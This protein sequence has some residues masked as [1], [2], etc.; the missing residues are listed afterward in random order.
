MFD[1]DVK[2]IPEEFQD[3]VIQRWQ[4]ILEKSGHLKTPAS[5]DLP[6]QFALVLMGS[7]YF[8]DQCERHPTLLKTLVEENYLFDEFNN[9]QLQL[10]VAAAVD[11]IDSVDDLMRSIREL[12]RLQMCR[13]IFRDI[14]RVSKMAETTQELSIFADFCIDAALGWLYQR[15]C[16]DMGRP[17]N[18]EGE[19]QHLVVIGMGKLGAYE[20]NLSSDVDLIFAYP[21]RGK[22]VG[23]LEID[24]QEFFTKLSQSLIKVLHSITVDGFVFRVDM[25]LRP[26]GNSGSLV[27]SFM[28]IEEYYT[29]HGRG[30]ERYAMIKA[31][32]I[33]GDKEQGQKLLEMLR[34]F[35][36]RRYVDY[37]VLESLRDMKSMIQHEVARN[38]FQDHVKLGEG[39]IREIEFLAQAFQLVHGG[40][41]VGLQ[42]PSVQI[43]LLH[44]ADHGYLPETAVSELDA[45][46]VFLR[47][48]EHGLQSYRDRQ[49]HELPGNLKDQR[50]LARIMGFDT[51]SEFKASL[52]QHREEV[53]KHFQNLLEKPYQA[54]EVQ[55]ELADWR[56]L[57]QDDVDDNFAISFLTQHGYLDV[58]EPWRHLCILK[59]SKKLLFLQ[60]DGR[61][62]IDRF[63]PMVLLRIS[64]KENASMLLMRVLPF[65]EAVVRRSAYFVLLLENQDLLDQ[66]LNLCAASPW[67]ADQIANQPVLIEELHT[68][69]EG[70]QVPDSNRLTEELVRQLAVTDDQENRL[71]VLSYFRMSHVLQIAAAEI[72]GRL[73]LMKVSDYLTNLAKVILQHV[74]KQVWQELLDRYGSPA[75]SDDFGF[76]IVAYGKLG[77]IE[78]GH[79]SDLDL[80]FIHDSQ[81]WARTSGDKSISAQE[82]YTKLAQRVIS[83]LRSRTTQGFLYEVDM[84]LRPSGNS[85]VLV[86]SL[87]AFVRYQKEDAWTWEHQALVRAQVV[88]GSRLLASKVEEVRRKILCQGRDKIN[89]RKDVKQMRNKMRNAEQSDDGFHLKKGKGGIIDIEFIVQYLVLAHAHDHPTLTRWTDNIRILETLA[90]YGILESDESNGLADA[91]RTYRAMAHRL[92]LQ[93]REQIV[94]GHEFSEQRGLVNKLWERLIG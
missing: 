83:M 13:I 1:L 80:V 44:L 53:N 20:L 67:I 43:I 22:T 8:A 29:K 38:N 24:N 32:V 23:S 64:Q 7:E 42:N 92:T 61:E 5:A 91:Y 58:A 46:Y 75:G 15:Q 17:C 49:T 50:R 60:K 79:S 45:A 57:W 33:A 85:G 3:E 90:E 65:I 86:S 21:E 41:D 54:G 56:A 14:N 4:Q 73:P 76:V 84:R 26:W 74:L 30:W 39:G 18:S 27:L 48:T 78:M 9:N 37:G 68:T 16:Q 51:W 93:N 52:D 40:R 28:A 10:N 62:R 47:N 87:S 70:F 36:F 69:S 88:G 82:F 55:A 81:L 11:G 34:P 6:A 59:S 31:R 72:T 35:V 12:R 63:M 94:P 71:N 19:L 66:L 77:G 89:L 2:K 25:R